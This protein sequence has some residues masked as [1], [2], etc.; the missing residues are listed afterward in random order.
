ME[1]QQGQEAEEGGVDANEAVAQLAASMPRILIAEGMAEGIARDWLA[2]TDRA[3]SLGQPAFPRFPFA[4][5]VRQGLFE[6]RRA[7]RLVRGLEGIESALASEEAGLASA[8]ATR[9]EAGRARISRLLVLSSDGSPRFYR[10]VE[11]LR[12]RFASRV[13]VV[14]L[15]CDENDLGAATFGPSRR[16]RALML[17]HKDG[18][19]DFLVVLD[20]LGRGDP[21]SD[22]EERRVPEDGSD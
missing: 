2:R 3:V 11:Q 22:R 13:A 4:E 16:V 1:I 18:V 17:D 12:T 21:S 5:S 7:R 19:I 20:D 9:P 15:E 10:L 14:M 8:P 6:A